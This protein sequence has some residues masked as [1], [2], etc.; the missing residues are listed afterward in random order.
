MVDH[1]VVNLE[2]ANS[3]VASFNMSAFNKG[4]RTIRVMGTKGEIYGDMGEDI[5][6]YFDF[7]TREKEILHP[8]SVSHLDET[9]A[10]GHAGG[11]QGIVEVL[12]EYLVNDYQ[13]DLL[14]EIEVSKDNHMIAFAAEESRLTNKVIDVDAYV[15]SVL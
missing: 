1:Q 6:T 10:G 15:K 13:G 9:L 7:A 5:V 3:A 14:S 2:F 12:Y 8:A 4:G 11:D